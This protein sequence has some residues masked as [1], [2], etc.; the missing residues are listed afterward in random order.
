MHSS[1][2]GVQK[3]ETKQQLMVLPWPTKTRKEIKAPNSTQ[4]HS[5]QQRLGPAPGK[6]LWVR[7]GVRQGGCGSSLNLRDAS[8]TTV[9]GFPLPLQ[10][11][12]VRDA[13]LI[14]VTIYFFP[15]REY[16]ITIQSHCVCVFK[17]C[18]TLVIAFCSGFCGDSETSGYSLAEVILLHF[19]PR[20]PSL[21]VDAVILI[22][23]QVLIPVLGIWCLGQSEERV[24]KAQNWLLPRSHHSPL[25]LPG[26]LHKSVFWV[27]V[28]S[29]EK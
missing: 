1:N 4:S 3:N 18:S 19:Q 6:A 12:R 15:L 21:P 9:L 17:T 29:L 7:A 24:P 14:L 13:W 16:Y 8:S 11:M 10:E 2:N 20:P 25:R 28:N 23:E 26:A 27:H 5:R 22:G